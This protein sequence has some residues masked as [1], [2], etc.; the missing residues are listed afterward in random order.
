MG[1]LNS[2]NSKTLSPVCLKTLALNFLNRSN[3]KT[4][5]PVCLNTLA[6]NS[7]NRSNLSTPARSLSTLDSSPLALHSDP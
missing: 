2:S 4:L 1:F 7:P 3:S 5:S 6:L